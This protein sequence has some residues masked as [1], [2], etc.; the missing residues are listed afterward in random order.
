M[1]Y[2]AIDG[3]K[4]G[5]VDEDKLRRLINEGDLGLNELVWSSGME[6]WRPVSEVNE[7]HPS[8]PPLPEEDSSSPPP[9][10]QEKPNRLTGNPDPDF[11]TDEPFSTSAENDGPTVGD[12][13]FSDA[14]KSTERE[15]TPD[16]A[17][18]GF[19]SRLLAYIIDLFITAIASGFL[20]VLAVAA[21]PSA[22][23]DSLSQGI[24]FLLTWLYFAGYESSGWQATFGKYCMGLKVTD[25]ERNRIGFWKATGRHFGK[26]ISGAILLIGFIMAAFTEK[27]QAL[28]DKMAGCLVVER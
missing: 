10:P 26:I 1:W 17:Y 19:G 3:E 24:G 15:S 22:D 28:H 13:N 18:A 14:S 11:G 12:R 8:P 5:P 7:I 21:D 2:Y 20:G 4:R 16:E 9:I 27:K 25:L 23:V 6:E